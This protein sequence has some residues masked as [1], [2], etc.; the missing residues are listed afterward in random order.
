VVELSSA[1]GRAWMRAYLFVDDQP[2]YAHTDTKGGFRL[3]RVPPGRYE[4]VC[5]L[6]SWR[7]R[8][9]ERD[10]ETSLVTRRF[11]APAAERR[12]PVE[13]RAKATAQEEF[14][15]GQADFAP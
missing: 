12:R 1:A 3:E 5:W 6:P 13:V 2:Y 4:L 14:A 8:R 7:L 15:F 9:Q 10:P 11:F